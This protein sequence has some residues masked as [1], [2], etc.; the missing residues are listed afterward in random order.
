MFQVPAG[1]ADSWNIEEELHNPPLRVITGRVKEGVACEPSTHCRRE[2][3]WM[4]GRL[5]DTIYMECLADGSGRERSGEK[6]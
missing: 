6:P 3:V 5:W 1:K 2:S 4:G